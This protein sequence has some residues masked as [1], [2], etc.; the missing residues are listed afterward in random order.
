M[1]DLSIVYRHGVG[2][3]LFDGLLDEAHRR[4]MRGI[5][6]RLVQA[7]AEANGWRAIC[8]A[9]VTT[10]TGSFDA[11]GEAHPGNAGAADASALLALAQT[12]AKARALCEAMNLDLTP[13][14][15][16]AAY[17]P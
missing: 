2:Y 4:G 9:R 6:L 5:T 11:L 1:L 14:E 12:R 15:E 7:P 8:S 17:R 3:V 10:P 13:I 16:L